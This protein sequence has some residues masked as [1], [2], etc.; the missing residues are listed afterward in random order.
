MHATA[1][2]KDEPTLVRCFGHAVE[3][4]SSGEAECGWVSS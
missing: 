4:D 1:I 3:R 2:N